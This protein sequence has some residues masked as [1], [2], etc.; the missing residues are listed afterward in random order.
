MLK[1]LAI[2]MHTLCCSNFWYKRI[3]NNR[4]LFRNNYLDF[5]AAL[6]LKF[7][8]NIAANIVSKNCGKRLRYSNRV[9]PYNSV[10]KVAV[11]TLLAIEYFDFQLTSGYND[12]CR[13]LS[14]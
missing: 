4:V 1:M 13:R 9:V 12:S 7:T 5:L 8:R 11:T 14:T 2:G 3:R 6:Q 10:R